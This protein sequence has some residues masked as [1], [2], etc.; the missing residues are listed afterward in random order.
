MLLFKIFTCS[1]INKFLN[2]RQ[3]LTDSEG[4][5][6]EDHLYG[7]MDNYSRYNYDFSLN[8]KLELGSSMD[9][10]YDTRKCVGSENNRIVYSNKQRINSPINAWKNFKVNNY[11]DLPSESG[12]LQKIFLVGSKMFLQYV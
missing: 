6:D 8:N 7:F 11:L 5:G 1:N 9:S 2:I 10:T 4:G 12:K 3:C